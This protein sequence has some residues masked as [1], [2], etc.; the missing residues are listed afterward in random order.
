MTILSKLTSIQ[1][2]INIPFAYIYIN[3]RN[4][5]TLFKNADSIYFE[6]TVISDDRSTKLLSKITDQSSQALVRPYSSSQEQFL[7]CENP[8]SL[9]YFAKFARGP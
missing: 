1:F 5:A 9:K 6:S 8:G 4:R 3:L 2:T 7:S